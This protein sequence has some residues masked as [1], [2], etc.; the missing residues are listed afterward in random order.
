MAPRTEKVGRRPSR[1]WFAREAMTGDRLSRWVE[2]GA[3]SGVSVLTGGVL[4]HFLDPDRGRSRRARVRS[5][6]TAA[7]RRPA[8]R[9]GRAVG[10]RAR[11][12]M[13]RLEGAGH[14]TLGHLRRDHAQFDDATLADKVRSEVLGRAEFGG[15]RVNVD[16]CK[17]VVHLRGELPSTKVIEKLTESAARVQGVDRV[18]SY[19]HLPGQSAPNKEP[20]L[21][22]NAMLSGSDDRTSPKGS[23]VRPIPAE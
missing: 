15:S 13:G 12:G 17:G 14:E 6:L 1:R 3:V 19:L 20:A 16:A 8:R 18:E 22:A 7:V 5:E 23:P 4:A 10:R 11:H 2:L 21:Q 9:I